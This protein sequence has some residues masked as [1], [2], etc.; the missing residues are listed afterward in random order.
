MLVAEGLIDVAV[1][2]GA[3]AWDLAAP[4]RRRAGGRRAA[5][6]LR[7][8]RPHRRRRRPRRPTG[9]C[10][11]PC[12]AIIRPGR[13]ARRASSASTP[14]ARSRWKQAADS[15]SNRVHEYRSPVLGPV[16]LPVPSGPGAHA[17][18]PVGVVRAHRP[19][20]RA[21][22]PAAPARRASPGSASTPT[23]VPTTP[24]R[25]RFRPVRGPS[26]GLRG[27]TARRATRGAGR[28]TAADGRG[29][30][31]RTRRARPAR[32][33]DRVPVVASSSSRRRRRRPS[34]PRRGRRRGPRRRSSSVVVARRP[35]EPQRSGRARHGAVAIR[36]TSAATRSTRAS[37]VETPGLPGVVD[38][39]DQRAAAEQPFASGRGRAHRGDRR[40]RHDDAG[41]GEHALADEDAAVGDDEV[42]RA[43][44]QHRG[45]REPADEPG[46]H[47]E[48]RRRAPPSTTA[49]AGATRDQPGPEER[50]DR[51]S[52]RG[53]HE[54]PPVRP[55]V[56]DAP[57]RPPRADA[58]G[59]PRV[60]PPP[61]GACS[62]VRAYPRDG[63]GSE[64][65]AAE[66]PVRVASAPLAT[67]RCARAP[68]RPRTPWSAP[69]RCHARR[70][71]RRRRRPRRRPRGGA[72]PGSATRHGRCPSVAQRR[73]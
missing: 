25:R 66:L 65:R 73:R 52:Q 41:P 56:A 29:N 42:G 58:P 48:D 44:A 53:D 27:S 22:S 43:P 38:V 30:V 12:C 64:R 4:G 39:H 49:S 13:V 37:P 14:A 71:A 63:P 23:P 17:P 50:G 18:H 60:P 36:S 70:G 11:T 3:S 20:R 10:T 35:S 45:H 33:P 5:H 16:D 1:E 61:I 32:C 34:R 9:T 68:R 67:R 15:S 59:T 47:H 6:R 72:P 26:R 19:A 40:A 7:R 8:H 21:P 51:G 55:D 2:P 24:G 57:A 28:R 62:A 31:G 46:R 69:R 54:H